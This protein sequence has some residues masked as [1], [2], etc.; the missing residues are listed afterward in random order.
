MPRGAA[1]VA[2]GGYGRGQLFP[3]SDVDVM[4]LL[5]ENVDVPRDAIERLLGDAVGCRPRARPRGAHARRMRTRDGRRH[6]GADEPA[7]APPDRRQ[8]Q[9]VRARS[10]SASL[11]DARR[12]RVLRRQD[13]RAAAAA[14][15]APRRRV[16]PRAERQGEPRRVAR[17]AD[18]HLDRARGRPGPDVA[19]SSP[20]TGSSRW[21]RRAPCRGTS[22]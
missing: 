3:H 18:G 11:D 8:P 16:Q 15:Q 12:A 19:A 4:V 17:P 1:L 5:P 22:S 6:H 20:R 13:A 2:V 10:S 21:P 14:P 9:A 7:R